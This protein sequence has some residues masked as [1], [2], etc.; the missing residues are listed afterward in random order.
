MT[1]IN[2]TTEAERD[3]IEIF[4]YG[5]EQLGLAQADRYAA[6]LTVKIENAAANPSFGADYAFVLD[7]V[8]RTQA[9]SHAVYYQTL[10]DSIL[11]LRILHDRASCAV[12][13]D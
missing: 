13:A 11:V 1:R 6:A 4:L 10:E 5:V 8:R 7:G 9:M 3:L 12:C 2:L